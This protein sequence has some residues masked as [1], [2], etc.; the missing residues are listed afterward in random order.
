MFWSKL[1]NRRSS[2]LQREP[3]RSIVKSQSVGIAVQGG[4]SAPVSMYFT[5]IKIE[6]PQLNPSWLPLP[7]A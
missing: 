5:L 2:A 4:F 6:N 3:V 7:Y 1:A